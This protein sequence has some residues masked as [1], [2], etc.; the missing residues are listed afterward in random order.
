MK[1]IPSVDALKSQF[2]YNPQ[3]GFFTSLV[4]RYKRPAGTVIRSL[5][6]DGYVRVSLLGKQYRGHLLA[7]LYMT[8][9]WP[10]HQVDH[11]NLNRSD[12]RW[13]NLRAAT[14]VQNYA[15]CG[16][17]RH[18]TSGYKGVTFFKRDGTWKAQI[19]IAGRAKHLGYFAN[20]ADAHKAY[21]EA[22]IK[23]HGEFARF[24]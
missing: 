14:R 6:G 10:V 17:R 8:G 7:W 22:A 18:N 12:N 5:D 13:E 19:S 1:K 9:I 11:R 4:H 15:N 21:Q 16:R 20:P 24:E 2:S 3:T 23:A